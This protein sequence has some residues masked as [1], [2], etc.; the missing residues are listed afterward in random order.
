MICPVCDQGLWHYDENTLTCKD[1]HH[2]PVQ[3]AKQGT[4]RVV[5]TDKP[6]IPAWLPGTVLG[7]VAL[8]SQIVEWTL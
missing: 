4:F 6:K 8:L 5:V 2:I 3:E 1:G 7:A